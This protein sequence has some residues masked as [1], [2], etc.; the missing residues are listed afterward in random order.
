MISLENPVS[1]PSGLIQN[2]ETLYQFAR[3]AQVINEAG[4]AVDAKLGDVQFVERSLP[5]GSATGEK[6]PWGGAHNIEGGFNVF[7]IVAGNNGTL[8]PRHTYAPLNSNTIMSAEAQGYHINYG[9]SWMLVI[10]FTDEGPQGR[11]ILTYSQSRVFGSD[12]FLAHTLLYSQH[13]SLRDMYF[14]EEDIAA[15]TIN[16]LILSSD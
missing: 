14:T 10:N 3:A 7:N 2:D 16:E 13:P 11:G 8:L 5:D 6:I 4:V 15:Y 1:T 12:H 9:S